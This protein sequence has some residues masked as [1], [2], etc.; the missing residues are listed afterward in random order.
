LSENTADERLIPGAEH[1][2]ADVHVVSGAAWAVRFELKVAARAPYI[3]RDALTS[4]AFKGAWNLRGAVA[5]GLVGAR[6]GSEGKK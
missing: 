6:R 1:R 2:Q 5:V 3:S 4:L